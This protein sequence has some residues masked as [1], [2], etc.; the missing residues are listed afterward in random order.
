M[1]VYALKTA[2]DSGWINSATLFT[3]GSKRVD[4][5]QTKIGTYSDSKPQ[6]LDFAPAMSVQNTEALYVQASLQPSIALRQA[7]PSIRTDMLPC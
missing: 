7:A 2:V 1:F 3:S 4:G 5:I 6:I